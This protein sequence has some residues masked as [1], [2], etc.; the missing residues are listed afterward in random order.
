MENRIGRL[1]A[2]ILGLSTATAACGGSTEAKATP[3][4]TPDNQTHTEVIVGPC[5]PGFK[6]PWEYQEPSIKPA[7][8]GTIEIELASFVKPMP[9]PDRSP[10]E[11]FY[12]VEVPGPEPTNPLDE[13]APTESPAHS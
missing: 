5:P 7:R 10:I 1:G 3:S 12:E 6:A 9:T 11:C 8:A 13:G 4:P 2:V